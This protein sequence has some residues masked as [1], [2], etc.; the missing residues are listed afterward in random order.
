[1]RISNPLRLLP[2]PNG[3]HDGMAARQKDVEDMGGDE[4]TATWDIT[5]S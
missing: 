5:V 2:C 4:A 1:M 3:R